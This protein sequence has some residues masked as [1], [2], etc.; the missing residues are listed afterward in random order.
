MNFYSEK[1]NQYFANVREDLISVV[2]NNP[3]QKI[4]EIGAGTGDTLVVLKKRG[5]ASFAAGVELFP[6]PDSNQD[7]SAIDKFIVGNIEQMD[8]DLE[9][10]F[11]D[12]IICG[13]VLEHLLDPWKTVEKLGRY[14]KTGGII[15]VSMPNIRHWSSL[16]KIFIKGNFEYEPSGIFDKTHYRF[17]CLKNIKALL[18]NK[19]LTPIKAVPNFRLIKRVSKTKMLDAV[20]FGMFSQFLSAQYIVISQKG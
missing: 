19:N 6:I 7:N 2:P 20:T 18:T 10:N 9:E 13:D 14:L 11:F 5:L 1:E 8:L 3:K 4:L 16:K 15:I 17:F 12:V